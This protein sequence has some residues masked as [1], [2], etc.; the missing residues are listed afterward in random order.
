MQATDNFEQMLGALRE[1]EPYIA[2]DGFTSGLIARLPE[3]SE[4][5]AWMSS[6]IMLVFTSVGSAIAA[7]QLPVAK[8]VSL[9]TSSIGSI[10]AFHSIP[11][12]GI[13]AVTTFLL[14]YA[15]VWMAQAEVI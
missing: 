1:T 12:L 3:A 5:P 4:L 11:M 14:A 2:D 10:P 6:L 15:V 13:G 7:W 8:L 9:T